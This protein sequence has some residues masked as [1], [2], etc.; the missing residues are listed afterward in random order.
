MADRGK[1]TRHDGIYK[2]KDGR[3]LLQVVL[4]VGGKRK[5]EEKRLPAHVL[6]RDAV[7]ARAQMLQA[8]L[9]ARDGTPA[10]TPH[11]A[12]PKAVK[13]RAVTTRP[14]PKPWWQDVPSATTRVSASALRTAGRRESSP[15]AI[16]AS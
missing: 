5:T 10:L 9:A 8:A 15:I 7:A 3:W 4:R 1:K 2:L 14:Q 11:A 16:E 12:P 6:E 13:A